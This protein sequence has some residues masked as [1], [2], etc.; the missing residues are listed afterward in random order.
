MVVPL[1]DLGVRPSIGITTGACARVLCE[2]MRVRHHIHTPHT[3]RVFCG[4]VGSEDRREYAV[5][6]D[7][8]NLSV[9][10]VWTCAPVGTS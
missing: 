4:D 2:C 8:V 6:G 10:A 3:G 5:V 7:V 9:R 1:I